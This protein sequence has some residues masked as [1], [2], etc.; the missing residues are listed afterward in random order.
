MKRIFGCALM[1]VLMPAL[2]SAQ[3]VGSLGQVSFRD[4]AAAQF[5]PPQGSTV[6]VFG[7]FGGGE[8]DNDDWFQVGAHAMMPLTWQNV[9]V[10]PRIAFQPGGDGVFIV[11]V[12]VLKELQNSGRI[13][14]FAGGGLAYRRIGEPDFSEDDADHVLGV[15]LVAGAQFGERRFTP[16]VQFQHTILF[17]RHDSFAVTGG[18]N[19]HVK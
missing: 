17:D 3:S 8:F 14:P 15:N 4:K 10:N 5:P 13:R 19:F 11:D 6:L 7:V 12:N 9:I 2:A 1:A 18:V 16:F